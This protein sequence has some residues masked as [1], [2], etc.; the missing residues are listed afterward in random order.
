MKSTL[1]VWLSFLLFAF[2][3]SV[4]S[5]EAYTEP[6]L[7]IQGEELKAGTEYIIGSI[8]FG[9][10][11]GDVSATNKTCPDD[12]IQ[13]SSDLLQGLPVTFSPASS[14]DDV[15][16]VST[17]L[18]IKFSIKKACDHSSVWKIQ[19]SSNS[20]V[21][22]F[23]T[24]GGEE[25]NPGID[26]LTNW[27]KIEKAGILGYKLVSCPEGICHCGVLCRDI[28][29]YREND[30]RRILSLSDKLSPFLVLFKKVGP[31]SSSI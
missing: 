30:G 15:I 7:D 25:G 3:L 29:I 1:L 22:W 18:N 11:G 24:T 13:Y 9:A 28:G 10:G 12:V 17:D 31:L 5:I 26:T 14:D 20:E 23:V 8:F 21:Q 4:P 19:K 16:R 27:F 2:V 6:V